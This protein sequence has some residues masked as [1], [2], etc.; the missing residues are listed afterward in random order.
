ME[1]KFGTFDPEF[2]EPL[3]FS[4]PLRRK[5]RRGLSHITLVGAAILAAALAGLFSFWLGMSW[6][7]RKA[8]RQDDARYS[9]NAHPQKS[10][11]SLA[12]W[13]A[14]AH[15]PEASAPTKS[16][17]GILPTA[18]TAKFPPAPARSA[19]TAPPHLEPTPTKPSAPLVAAVQ[20]RVAT[21]STSTNP[22]SPPALKPELAVAKPPPVAPSISPWVAQIGATD[23][24]RLADQEWQKVASLMGDQMNGLSEHYEKVD[25]NGS[26][27][28]RIQ[29]S[30]FSSKAAA[31]KFCS[32]LRALGHACIAK[33]IN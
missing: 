16:P 11:P 2:L 32:D 26:A 33:K 18:P 14:K 7:P 28:L 3:V 21:I 30:G 20:P 10:A 12:S 23:D 22:A 1:R 31:A 8:L 5:R 15:P 19:A 4:K 6:S 13:F 25:S 24:Q 29:A 9:A 27:L 17:P